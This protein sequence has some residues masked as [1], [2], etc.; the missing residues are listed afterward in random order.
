MNWLLWNSFC[1]FEF[2]VFCQCDS[3]SCDFVS[4][5]VGRYWDDY[6]LLQGYMCEV[7]VAYFRYMCPFVSGFTITIHVYFH[8]S[9]LGWLAT[10]PPIIP[11]TVYQLFMPIV[12]AAAATVYNFTIVTENYNMCYRGQCQPSTTT[13]VWHEGGFSLLSRL[14]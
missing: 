4:I 9:L 12:N 5:D 7:S 8:N 10:Q 14:V 13:W 1:I 2:T 6:T 11:A 3:F